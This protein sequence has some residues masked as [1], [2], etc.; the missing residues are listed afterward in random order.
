[1][2]FS[3]VS[4]LQDGFQLQELAYPKAEEVPFDFQL[5]ERKAMASVGIGNQVNAPWLD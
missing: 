2:I 1:M 5:L 4:S 3:N